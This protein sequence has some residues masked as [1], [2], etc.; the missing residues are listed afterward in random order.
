MV[1]RLN[2]MH[3]LSTNMGNKYLE[4]VVLIKQQLLSEE[5]VDVQFLRHLV[6]G[7][8]QNLSCMFVGLKE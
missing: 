8:Y 3:V 1:E 7:D 2:T 5:L 4:F 6:I